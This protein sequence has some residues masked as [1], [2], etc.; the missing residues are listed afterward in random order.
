[1][2]HTARL[3]ALGRLRAGA[4][5]AAPAAALRCRGLFRPQGTRGAFVRPLL[6]HGRGSGLL[7]GL[8]GA[9]ALHRLKSKPLGGCRCAPRFAAGCFRDALLAAA[10]VLKSKPRD[11]LRA[12]GCGL[13]RRG[14]AATEPTKRGTA[15][16]A[17]LALALPSRPR[18]PRAALPRGLAQRPSLC[19]CPGIEPNVSGFFRRVPCRGEDPSTTTNIW[20]IGRD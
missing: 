11:V 4:P 2:S 19:P 1:M 6:R 7:G 12:S 10:K 18:A 5:A 9:P 3:V 15:C 17:P 13:E 20:K 8:P 14:M 16:S